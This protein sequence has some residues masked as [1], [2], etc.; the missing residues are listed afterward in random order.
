MSDLRRLGKQIGLAAILS[1]AMATSSFAQSAVQEPN[2][3]ASNETATRPWSAPVGHRQPR[4]ADIPAAA[5]AS[6]QI[7]DQEDAIVDRKIRGICRGC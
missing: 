3:N 5:S 2:A 7:I 4:A 1:A 6:Q